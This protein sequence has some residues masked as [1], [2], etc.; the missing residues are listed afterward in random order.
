T[1]LPYFTDDDDC[2]GC[3]QCVAVCPGLA[4]TLVDYR[5][6]KESP[7]VTFPLELT[8]EKIEVGQTV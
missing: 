2:I 1:Q 4:I 5:K 3:G 8:H 6:D 7:V